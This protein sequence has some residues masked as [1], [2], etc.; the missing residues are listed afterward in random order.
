[1]GAK[2]KPFDYQTLKQSNTY[3]SILNTNI[4]NR[5]GQGHWYRDWLE[6]VRR[7]DSLIN[8][9]LGLP[10]RDTQQTNNPI[11]SQSSK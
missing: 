3:R 6:N 9:E 2:M 4:A 11:D 8:A 7:I 5:Q 10:K 1:M